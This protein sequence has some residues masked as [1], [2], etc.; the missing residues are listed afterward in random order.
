MLKLKEANFEDIDKEWILIRDMPADENG[1]TNSWPGVSK[2]FFENQAIPAMINFSKGKDIPYWMVPETYLFLWDDD[3]IV[4]LFRLRQH[5]CESLIKGAGHIGYY[6]A[7]EYRGRGYATEGL[8]LLIEY[9]K[10]IVPEDEFYLRLDKGN[11]ASL[12]VMEKNGGYI[13]D[14]DDEKFYVRIPKSGRKKMEQIKELKIKLE[15]NEWPLEYI[16]HDRPIARAIVFDDEMNFYFV[17]AYRD[18]DFG[19]ATL[20]ETAGGGVEKNEDLNEAIKRELKE[21]LGAEV[22][23]ICKLG[24]VS[25]YYN[26]IHR[27]NMNNYFLCKVI[28][29]GEKRLTQD[30]IESFH[31]S[32]LKMS[33]EQALEEYERCRDSAVGR[34]VGN[35]EVPVLK[36]AKNV[37]D[38]F[39]I[40]YV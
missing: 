11:Q 1:M 19:K 26:L 12:R 32:T 21:E 39:G 22:Q 17:R 31:L 38:E 23:V 20:I 4:G 15:D 37:I 33:Y 34:L 2:M 30:E 25:D 3:M 7:K 35:R 18:D 24:E 10:D 8:R 27:H 6:I 13:V 14:E 36:Y 16:D 40:V 5:L 29:F 28:S 9:A